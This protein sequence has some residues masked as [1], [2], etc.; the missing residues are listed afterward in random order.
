MSF[1]YDSTKSRKEQAEESLEDLVTEFESRVRA[2]RESRGLKSKSE[3]KL[4]AEPKQ[5][6][7]K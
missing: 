7:P 1:T 6:Q 2:A 5:Q 3:Q 4:G